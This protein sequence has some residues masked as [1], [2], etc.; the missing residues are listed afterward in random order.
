M[1]TEKIFPSKAS[2]REIEMQFEFLIS[3]FNDS[4]VLVSLLLYHFFAIS[5]RT[6]YLPLNGMEKGTKKG[7]RSSSSER[8]VSEMSRLWPDRK[9]KFMNENAFSL[10]TKN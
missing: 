5:S 7:D 3:S 10:K 4:S 2:E 9:L 6:I 1:F 8:R